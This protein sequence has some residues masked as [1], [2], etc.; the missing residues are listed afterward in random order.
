M[1]I[2]AAFEEEELDRLYSD[3]AKSTI[4]Y[5]TGIVGNGKAVQQ[6][7]INR[8][9][10][11]RAYDIAYGLMRPAQQ[12]GLAEFFITKAGKAIGFRF[13]PPFDRTFDLD[14][15]GIGDGDT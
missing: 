15:F 6:R 2:L 14:I 5:E 13:Y 12:E 7:S 8:Y 9:D 11:L 3:G 1:A 4:V 10:G